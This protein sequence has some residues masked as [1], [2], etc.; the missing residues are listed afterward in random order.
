M[1][2][3]RIRKNLGGKTLRR[4]VRYLAAICVG[5]A[6]TMAWQAYGEGAKRIIATR[7]PELGWSPEVRETIAGW[8]KPLAA[9]K[10]TAARPPVQET[11]DPARVAVAQTPA[12]PSFDP[13]Q[14]KQMAQSLDGLRQTVERLAAAQ[15]E[16]GREMTKL[17]AADQEILA[18]ITPAPSPLNP[19]AASTRKPPT[20]PPQR[21]HR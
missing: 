9:P 2:A 21:P 6:G 7:A 5:V 3:L 13:D 12:T 17:Q 14:A 10:K 1:L 20:G 16:I 11:Q 8:T 19:P 18:R 15:E 4:F